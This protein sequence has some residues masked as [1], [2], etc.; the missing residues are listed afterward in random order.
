MVIVCRIS[1][2]GDSA[3]FSLTYQVSMIFQKSILL[4]Y[5]TF[6]IL[7][8]TF[9]DEKKTFPWNAHLIKLAYN[10]L[11]ESIPSRYSQSLLVR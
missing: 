5:Q 10:P 7:L 11:H 9:C 4:V 1:D 8:P 2:I 3:K 6:M